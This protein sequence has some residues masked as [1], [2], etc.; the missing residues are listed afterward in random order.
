MNDRLV[1]ENDFPRSDIDVWVVREARS[2]IR[3]L[4]NDL[5]KLMEQI[6]SKLEEL[7]SLSRT[8]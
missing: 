2:K 8:N 1:D 7:H 3:V 5:R 4:E 6:Q